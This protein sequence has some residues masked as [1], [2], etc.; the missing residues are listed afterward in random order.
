MI[1]LSVNISYSAL[2]G[3]VDN[4]EQIDYSQIN[5]GEILGKAD[6]YYNSAINSKT[7]N[8]DMT[9]ALNLYN[10]LKNKEPQNIIYYLKLGQL[11][12]A[13][14]KDSLAK[15]NFYQAIGIK[16]KRPEPYYYL[17][18]LFYKKGQYRKAIKAY[19]KAYKNGYCSNYEMLDKMNKIY[20][21][22][23]DTGMTA[24]FSPS[25]I[26]S[27]EE[28]YSS[29]EILEDASIEDGIQSIYGQNSYNELKELQ[30]SN[31]YIDVKSSD[32]SML[33]DEIP[34]LNE[35]IENINP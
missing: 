7:V 5:K 23:G 21:K 16:P 30:N 6:F 27:L 31:I 32:D 11:Y 10:I 24:A 4:S 17:G 14:G 35:N 12:S 3:S 13:I 28:L 34:E 2:Q 20:R 29:L 1:F 19:Q 18:N 22:L 33:F 15:E 25:E 26:N 8:D 9:Q